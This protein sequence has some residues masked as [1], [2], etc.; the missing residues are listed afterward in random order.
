MP[1][2]N[3][4]TI[5]VDGNF[6]DWTAAE[7]ID[8][9]ANF[10]PG[11]AL[12]GTEQ[13]GVYYIGIEATVT[14]DPVI[15]PGTTIWLN[16]D[17]NTATGYSPFDSIGADYNI[18]FNA[19][20][21]PYLY[22]GAAGQ[23]LVDSTPLTYALSPNGESL[24]I[25]LPSSLITPASGPAPTNI[26]IAAEI[27]NVGGNSS[28]A[29]YLPGDYNSPEYTI[30]D[31][32]TLLPQTDTHKVAIVYSDTSASLYFNQSAYSDL[33]MAAEN[34]ARMAGVSYDLIDESQLTNISN[35]VGYSALIFP[36]M[37]DVN[38]AQLPAIISTLTSAVYN[39]GIS[40]I[41]AG[42]FLTNNQTGAALPGNAY[43]NMETLLDLQRYTGGNSANVTITA[44]DVS[45]PIMQSYTA[46]QLI[47]SYTN[48]GYSAYQGVQT[49]A[50]VLVNQN[51]AG[52]GTLPGVVETTTGGTN[53]T[54][55]NDGSAGR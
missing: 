49:P 3:N 22:T 36:A 34:Q 4:P 39:Y 5:T 23:T 53:V 46:G 25:A 50:D 8:N 28:T 20:G 9:P 55:R 7:R 52:V 26:N 10:V 51:V 17:Q 6:S 40:I 43:A 45:N 47:Q 18:T 15:G 24:E 35:L 30:T 14:T 37:P 48:E 11:Y 16:T 32:A 1:I 12:Y 54:I 19:S 44:N 29:V 42:D 21:I 41:T 2:T 31:P 13:N 27:D 33:I 38:T